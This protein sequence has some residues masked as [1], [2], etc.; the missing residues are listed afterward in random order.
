MV[1]Y[2]DNEVLSYLRSIVIMYRSET[3]IN[4]CIVL[5]CYDCIVKGLFVFIAADKV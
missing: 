4:T 3:L 1:L 5:Y 2:C